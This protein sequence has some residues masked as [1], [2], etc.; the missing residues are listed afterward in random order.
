MQQR[1]TASHKWVDHLD[2]EDVAFVKR[3]MVASGSLKEMAKAYG[4]SY[5]TIR[6]RLDRLIEK[7]KIV[8]SQ[9]ILSPFERAA[10]AMCAD[11]RIDTNTLRTLLELHR[12]ELEN[13]DA[14][15]DSR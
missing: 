5:P 14:T 3:F 6:L 12:T 8:D 9:Q 2:E 7:I 11:G 10:R 1:Q 13:N 15:L 4:I